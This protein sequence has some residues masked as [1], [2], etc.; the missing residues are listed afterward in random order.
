M[1]MWRCEGVE[2]CECGD[3]KVGGV[4][5]WRCGGCGVCSR[6]GRVVRSVL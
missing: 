1:V 4:R 5:V 2:V 3:V 6:D